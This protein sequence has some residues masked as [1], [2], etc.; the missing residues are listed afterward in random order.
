MSTGT[1][2]L[3]AVPAPVSERPLPESTYRLQ[4]HAGFTFRDATRIVPYLRELGI[5]HVYASPYLKARP[6][7]THGYDIVNHR[8]LNPEVGTPEEHD[9]FVATIREHGLGL[10]LDIVPNHMGIGTNENPWWERRAGERAGGR[11]SRTPSTSPGNPPRGRNSKIRRSAARCSAVRTVRCWNPGPLRLEFT[12]GGF[13][14]RYGE[15]NFPVAPREL[16]HRP[17]VSK[18]GTSEKQ[19]GQ[20][21]CELAEY[22]SILDGTRAPPRPDRDRSAKAGDRTASWREG[23]D[24]AAAPRGTAGAQCGRAR[25]LPQRNRQRAST[26]RPAT[27][28]A[29]TSW[30][31]CSRT[32]ATGCRT[33]G[34]ALEEINYRRFFDVN[35]LRALERRAA[36]TFSRP[37]TRRSSTRLAEGKVDGL[38]VDHPDGLYDP[39]QHF[40]RLQP[41]GTPYARAEE[42]PRSKRPWPPWPVGR[43]RGTGRCTCWSRR[44]SR[45]ESR[46]LPDDWPVAGTTGYEF[47]NAVNGLFVDTTA[48]REFTKLYCDLSENRDSFAEVLYR[49]K[50]LILMVS[51]ASELNTLTYQLDRLAQKR[52]PESRTSP[53]TGCAASAARGD[54]VLPGVPLV[55]RREPRPKSIARSL[56]TAVRRRR[57]SAIR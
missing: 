38:R 9:A 57:A 53:S 41:P 43:H 1:P 7:S 28:G 49:S 25:R 56:K 34:W 23:S 18:G 22:L 8:V 52:A 11:G 44:S 31:N 45:Q 29:S 12:D 16:H 3:A 47:L 35:D 48:A 39:R 26:A 24:Q 32:S 2:D 50:R 20:I 36:R 37:F 30:M 13:A 51:L 15:R 6:G 33:G 27:R 14:V 54:R 55:H 4:F 10:I 42:E 46:R 5:T 19:L 17:R 40:H 21:L